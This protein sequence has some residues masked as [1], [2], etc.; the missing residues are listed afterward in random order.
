MVA[1]ELSGVYSDFSEK[2]GMT[3][4]SKVYPS[5]FGFFIFLDGY[6]WIYIHL[7]KLLFRI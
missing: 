7:I 3:L 1:I 5:P 4:N 2:W 6:S